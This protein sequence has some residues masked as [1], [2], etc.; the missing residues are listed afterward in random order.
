MEKV[1]PFADG[2]IIN[3]FHEEA[4]VESE[5]YEED[6]VHIR[7]LCPGYL[8]DYIEDRYSAKAE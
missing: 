6:G 5:N 8:A 1:I 4:E 7:A 2:Q 3:R